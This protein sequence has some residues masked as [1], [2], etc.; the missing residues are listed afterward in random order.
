MPDRPDS[1]R[2]KR[3]LE[4]A[5]AHA[6]RLGREYVGTESLLIGLLEEETGPAA[7]LLTHLG[8]TADAVRDA[9]QQVTGDEL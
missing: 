9:W 1:T 4:L 5:D 3:A 6:A 8:V 2:A 7:Q